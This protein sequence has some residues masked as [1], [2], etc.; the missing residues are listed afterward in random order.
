MEYLKILGFQLK[1]N[2]A[3]NHLK[4]YLIIDKDYN[5]QMNESLRV[6][7][8]LNPDLVIYPEM[9]YSEEY[10][11]KLLELSKDKIIIAGSV[12][13][14]SQN[15]TIVYEN[16]RKI[17]IPKR[18]ASGAEPMTRFIDKLDPDEFINKYLDE[19]TFILKNKKIIILNCMEYYYIAYYLGRKYPN[20]FA[21]VSPCS[22]SN[23]QVF[24]DESAALHNHN[25]NVYSFVVN[26]VSE[27]NNKSYAKGE[28]YIYGPI[29][30]HEKEWLSSEG[31]N[32]GK[33]NASILNLNSDA[34]YFYGE[35]T[36]NL[37]PY[38]RSDKYE[39]NPKKVLIKRLGG[40]VYY[41]KNND[42]IF[43]KT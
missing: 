17:G 25:E 26:C 38:G 12:Y 19:H 23:Q 41:G 8:D 22:N 11:D 21:F 42:C 27:Y 35:F 34:S 30:Y 15:T 2:L 36:N 40:N 16:G 13:I 14:G 31:I 29:Q 28:S 32:A 18:Y 20:I 1:V 24:I 39:N 10:E 7:K 5:R 37:V 43:P 4:E 3:S 9:C 6:I 33:H